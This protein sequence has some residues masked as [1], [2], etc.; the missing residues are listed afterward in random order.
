MYRG[1]GVDTLAAATSVIASTVDQVGFTAPVRG[2]GVS[3]S[4]K[5][6]HAGL[7]GN[8]SL[9]LLDEAHCAKP[10]DQTMQAV[11]NTAD[12]TSRTPHSVLCR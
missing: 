5:P 4:M 2:Y 8:D 7:V 3:D 10:F 11:K 6:I 9:I 1:N 12:G